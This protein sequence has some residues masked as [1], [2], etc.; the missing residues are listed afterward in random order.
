MSKYKSIIGRGE[1]IELPDFLLPKIP[2]KTDTGAYTS[3][4]HATNIKEIKKNGKKMLKFHIMDSHP[5]YHYSRE[6]ETAHYSSVT[7]SNSFGEMQERYAVNLKVKM[8]GKVFITEF[9]LADR[10]VKTFPVL[11]GRKLLNKRF[12]VDPNV[13]NI[14]RKTL[15]D[16]LKLKLV[17]DDEPA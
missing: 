1:F 4:I 10:S 2:A 8:A 3:S 14:D 5:S 13:T 12:L 17:E 16:N 7:V 9:T 11:L 15:K 6:V